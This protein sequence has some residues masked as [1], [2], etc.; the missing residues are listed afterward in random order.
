L[1]KAKAF[2][3]ANLMPGSNMSASIHVFAKQCGRLFSTEHGREKLLSDH[4]EKPISS[5]RRNSDPGS[6]VNMSIWAFER[7]DSEIM[8][9]EGG[10]SIDFNELLEKHSS[11][12]HFKRDMFPMFSS[13]TVMRA[14]HDLLM[15]STGQEIE[16]D[17]N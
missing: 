8:S 1:T 13:L 4:S 10:R 17:L 7:R 3:C 6:N 11:S 2:I 14:K 15:I 5:L 16:I 9:T 12:I